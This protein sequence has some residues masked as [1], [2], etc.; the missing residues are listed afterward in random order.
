MSFCKRRF[1]PILMINLCFSGTFSVPE[2]YLQLD[3]SENPSLF[4]D[5]P[6][7]SYAHGI[8]TKDWLRIKL[9]IKL[10]VNQMLVYS[11]LQVI[12]LGKRKF[13]VGPPLK[14]MKLRRSKGQPIIGH[15][16]LIFMMGMEFL[17]NL[18][19]NDGPS[20]TAGNPELPQEQLHGLF[21]KTND[22]LDGDPE[23]KNA[24]VRPPK[25]ITQPISIKNPRRN[26]RSYQ[27]QCCYCSYAASN[28][29]TQTRRFLGQAWRYV[30]S[31]CGSTLS[32]DAPASGEER[33]IGKAWFCIWRP[34]GWGREWRWALAI[35]MM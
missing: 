33:P 4:R 31:G 27:V 5:I 16:L 11:P 18:N 10:S 15:T 21:D 13:A 7:P 28:S 32:L 35:N 34:S 14:W 26:R 25:P 2:S 19:I 12:P 1:G 22:A 23:S 6:W 17:R 9:S 20:P 30:A 8:P 29:C 24:R 3:Y